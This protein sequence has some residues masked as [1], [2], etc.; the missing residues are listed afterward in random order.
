MARW[1]ADREGKALI[2]YGVS[3]GHVPVRMKVMK[4]PSTWLPSGD[5]AHREATAEELAQIEHLV[6]SGMK[7][8]ALAVGM[9]IQ[10]TAAASHSEVLEMFRI[11]AKYNATVHVH[12]RFQGTKEP[13]TGL[14]ALEEV[15]A[16]AAATGRRC[17]SCI[18]PAWAFAIHRS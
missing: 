15:I 17:R 10:Y 6:D 9:G 2:N 3:S 14:A 11:A 7:Q 12:I 1:Y 16:A 8:G 4:D 5:A 18:S 13:D